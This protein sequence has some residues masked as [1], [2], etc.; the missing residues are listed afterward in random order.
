M[1]ALRL[2]VLVI[3]AA[4]TAACA[5]S[6]IVDTGESP[7]RSQTVAP[8]PTARTDPNLVN[9]HDY[10]A[11]AGDVEG[12]YFT[13]PS[14]KWSC[15]IRPRRQVGCQAT[16]AQSIGVS[17]APDKVD[18]PNGTSVSPNAIAVG[19]EGGPGFVWVEAPGFS[20][21]T[22]KAMVLDFNTTLAAA[23]F[24]CNVQDTGVSCENE[25][26]QQ[27]FMFSASEFVPRYSPVPG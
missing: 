19:D 23:G 18:G 10:Y 5:D 8:A 22:G 12:Y 7:P 3:T 14:G 21:K 9:A 11:T 4:L 6:V 1:T 26:T 20:L 25:S 13:T 16:G 24:R 2:M 27:G 15:A 17:G